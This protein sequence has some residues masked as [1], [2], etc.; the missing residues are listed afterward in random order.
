MNS[1]PRDGP[2]CR[3][4]VST[5][6]LIAVDWLRLS[7]SQIGAHDV[8]KSQ[9]INRWCRQCRLEW[10]CAW[11]HVSS[12]WCCI[13]VRTTVL[14]SALVGAGLILERYGG[15]MWMDTSHCPLYSC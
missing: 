14:L 15:I 9:L 6:S 1:R 4:Q 5:Q 10:H 7:S 13:A 2:G 12:H 3:C 11:S 8:S